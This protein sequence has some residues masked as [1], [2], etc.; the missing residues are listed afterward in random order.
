MLLLIPFCISGLYHAYNDNKKTIF[1]F[2][3]FFVY[4]SFI[5]II[6]FC[7]G[8]IDIRGI[9]HLVFYAVTFFLYF[10]FIY[11]I[12][13]EV[14]ASFFKKV[15]SVAII[16]TVFIGFLE[17][18]VFFSRGW[19]AYANFMNHDSNVGIFA[20]IPRMR[21][22]FNEPSHLALFMGGVAP[23]LLDKAS[24]LFKILFFVGFILT[25]SSSMVIGIVLAGIVIFI[26][27]ITRKKIKKSLILA[28]LCLGILLFLS[29]KEL[30][31]K[32]IN[33]S[34]RDQVRYNAFVNAVNYLIQNP[35]RFVT[36]S[37]A[38]SYYQLAETGLFN[39]YLQLLM[40]VGIEGFLIFAMFLFHVA[41]FSKMAIL[42]K[43]WLLAVL[44]QF[45]GMNHYYIPGLWILLAWINFNRKHKFL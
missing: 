15:L 5:T 9:N 4:L 35:F 21:S 11:A 37:G 6:Y 39:W 19:T 10:F 26:I 13:Y 23:I 40:E 28:L 18:Y 30:W 33:I 38:T 2:C 22:T 25:F 1:L 34:T 27:N 17:I 29:P 31:E 43:F 16:I 8:S 14:G 44:F 3:S 24:L 41:H 7:A 45:I 42:Y 20:G 32:V 12:C 36:G